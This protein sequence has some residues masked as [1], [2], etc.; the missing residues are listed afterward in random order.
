MWMKW[1]HRLTLVY[2]YTLILMFTPLREW[3]Y[4]TFSYRLLGANLYPLDFFIFIFALFVLVKLPVIFKMASRT[5]RLLLQ[6]ILL[7]LVFNILVL[8]PWSI[9]EGVRL[10]TVFRILSPRL[11][12]FQIPFLFLLLQESEERETL[13]RH[14]NY[15]IFILF[16]IG[17]FRLATHKLGYTSTGELRLFWGGV[18]LIFGFGVA[19]NFFRR[20][21]YPSHVLV[22]LAS[23][24]GIITIN[25][26]SGYLALLVTVIIGLLFVR[27]RMTYFF[28]FLY[29][30]TA[31]LTILYFTSP[32]V[33][34]DMLSRLSLISDLNE[35]NA[36]DRLNRWQLA[37]QFF[38][39]HWFLGSKLSGQMYLVVLERG[40]P[41]H[42]FL[43]E[44]LTRQGVLGVIFFLTVLFKAIAIGFRD[45]LQDSLS[46]ALALSLIFYLSFCLF[47]TNFLHPN[48]VLFLTLP[49]AAIMAINARLGVVGKSPNPSN[50]SQDQ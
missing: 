36:L 47:N 29:S 15:L 31:F 12:L 46:L 24:F 22:G 37:W 32:L 50:H 20:L 28:I 8:V 25:H 23:I 33:I 1:A 17:V 4:T 42:N 11:A 27:K 38:K 2:L 13:L 43:L 30:L 41:P 5:N 6:L 49:L 19:V 34:V 48:N 10:P 3:I 7:Y 16:L 40:S 45:G 21:Q 35:G 39:A 9:M 44:L 18:A 14:I 26:R